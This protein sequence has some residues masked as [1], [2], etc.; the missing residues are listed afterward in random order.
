MFGVSLYIINVQVDAC[1]LEATLVV[2]TCIDI[3]VDWVTFILLAKGDATPPYLEAEGIVR[4][5]FTNSLELHII[6][7]LLGY[8]IDT[9]ASS[10]INSLEASKLLTSAFSNSASKCGRY[11]SEVS[12]NYKVNIIRVILIE[13]HLVLLF[14]FIFNVIGQIKIPIYGG[15]WPALAVH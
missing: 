9:K 13:G 15:R 10:C 1:G 11:C 4:A 8:L 6:P 5:C 7:T 14:G 3:D 2:P 12:I